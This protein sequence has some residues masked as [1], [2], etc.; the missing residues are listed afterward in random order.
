M[1]RKLLIAS[2]IASIFFF[3]SCANRKV[4]RIDPNQ[5]TDISGR[6]NDTDSKLVAN[7]MITDVL[8]R[9]WRSEFEQKYSKKP[10]VIVGSV[11]NKSSEHIESLTFIK[12]LEKAFI[13]S[14]TV[15][16]VQSADERNQVREERNDQQTFASEETR[17]K[18]GKEKGADFMLN[19][20]ITSIIDQYKNQKTVAYQ[21][22]LELTNLETNEKVWIGEKKIKKYIKN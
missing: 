2:A 12:D 9:P 14:G 13:N 20:V 7:E 11:K 15:S 4:T 21:I 10:T 8:T 17:K 1:I 3:A 5:Q 19:G 22:N 16:V 18:W 6:W